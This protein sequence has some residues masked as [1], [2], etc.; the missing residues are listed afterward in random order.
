[1]T[2]W[3]TTV[4]SDHIRIGT[5]VDAYS[6]LQPQSDQRQQA[7]NLPDTEEVTGSIPVPPA[8]SEVLWPGGWLLTRAKV[9]AGRQLSETLADEVE[10][11]GGF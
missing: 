11:V 8:S 7:A 5:S 9:R 10:A 6:Q 3:V 2:N 1:V 4:G